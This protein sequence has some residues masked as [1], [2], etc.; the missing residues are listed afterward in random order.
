MIRPNWFHVLVALAREELHGA[1]IADDVL[2]QTGGDVRLWPAT[3]YRTLDDMVAG[4]LIEELPERDR[5]DGESRRKRYYRVTAAG[6]S[7]L[8]E[9]ADRLAGFARAARERL[10]SAGA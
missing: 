5:P 3:L 10:G 8:A 2:R 1:A 7:E 4:G 6:R 9:A